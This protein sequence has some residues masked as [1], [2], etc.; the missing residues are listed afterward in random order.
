MSQI[1]WRPTSHL[2][3]L[4]ELISGFNFSIFKMTQAHWTLGQHFV[5]NKTCLQF[6]CNAYSGTARWKRLTCSAGDTKP[7]AE[8]S[9]TT[10]KE[11]QQAYLSHVYRTDLRGIRG[12]CISTPLGTCASATD[13][14]ASQT[15]CSKHFSSSFQVSKYS[16]GPQGRHTLSEVGVHLEDRYVP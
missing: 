2:F 15:L 5:N 1:S 8:P 7:W 13:P 10:T 14:P 4:E 12:T 6:K 11:K 16:S 9:P 3:I